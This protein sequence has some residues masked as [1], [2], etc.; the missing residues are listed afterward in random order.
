MD[1]K[2]NIYFTHLLENIYY[3]ETRQS[4]SDQLINSK[5]LSTRLFQIPKF[6]TRLSLKIGFVPSSTIDTDSME[7]CVIEEEETKFI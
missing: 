5:S 4:F 3:F 7:M 1:N 6:E 2:H